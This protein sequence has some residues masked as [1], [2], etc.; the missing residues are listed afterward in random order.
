MFSL[1]QGTTYQRPA[2]DLEGESASGAPGKT[3]LAWFQSVHSFAPEKTFLWKNG[4]VKG[5]SSY[6]AFE[7][8]VGSSPQSSLGVFVLANFRGKCGN[9]AQCLGK[10]LLEYICTGI[11]PPQPQ[12][13]CGPQDGIGQIPSAVD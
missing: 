3:Y 5:F 9:A 4:S 12:E 11:A 10:W 7:N 13:I 2:C 1:Q 6:L 8:W